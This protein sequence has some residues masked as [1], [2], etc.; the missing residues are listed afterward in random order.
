M[1]QNIR[2]VIAS[3]LVL[4]LASCSESSNQ[5]EQTGVGPSPNLPEP[6]SKLIPTINIAAAKGW[7]RDA[8]PTPASDLAVN[9]FASGLDHPRSLYVLPNGDV[10]VAETNAPPKS[11][12]IGG[13]KRLVL[14]DGAEAGRRRACRARTASP[15]CATPTVTAWPRR[16][17]SS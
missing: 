16:A 14:Q 7:P 12:G 13:I 4:L 9:A 15:C 8:K 2:I 1:N 11:G 10:L 5:P 6:Q 17:P 3:A